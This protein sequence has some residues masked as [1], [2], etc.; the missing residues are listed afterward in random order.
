MELP[1]TSSSSSSSS[2]TARVKVRHPPRSVGQRRKVCGLAALRCQNCGAC[3][4]LVWEYFDY[5]LISFWA[6]PLILRPLGMAQQF[7]ALSTS[8]IIPPISC[9]PQLIRIPS[10]LDVATPLCFGIL[11]HMSRATTKTFKCNFNYALY[12]PYKPQFPDPS[13]SIACHTSRHAPKGGWLPV[14]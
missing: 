14:R 9:K 6:T 5:Q 3:I 10:Q 2:A 8:K 1:A 4:N 7:R 13:S 11:A 12:S